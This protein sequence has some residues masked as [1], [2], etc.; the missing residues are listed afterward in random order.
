MVCQL[1]LPS[2]LPRPPTRC[3]LSSHVSSCKTN[4]G[5]DLGKRLFPTSDNLI[6]LCSDLMF[7]RPGRSWGRVTSPSPAISSPSLSETLPLQNDGGSGCRLQKH[8]I[9]QI[10]AKQRSGTMCVPCPSLSHLATDIIIPL[11][12]T[13]I[14]LSRG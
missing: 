13:V 6:A 12:C 11:T 4:L 10:N 1:S 8:S 14:P 3:Y 5:E 2:V 7:P 9:K